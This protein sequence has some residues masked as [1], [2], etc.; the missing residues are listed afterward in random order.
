MNIQPTIEDTK[1]KWAPRYVIENLNDST[2]W[3]G[4]LFSS[5]IKLAKSYVSHDAAVQEMENRLPIGETYYTIKPV[6]QKF[7]T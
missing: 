2:Y 6:W 4:N 5:D 7:D 1:P 3:M